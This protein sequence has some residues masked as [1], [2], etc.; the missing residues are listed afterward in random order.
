MSRSANGRSSIHEGADG[1]WHGWVTVGVRPDGTPDRRHRMARTKAELT[2]KVRELEKKRDAGQ[3]TPAGSVPTVAEWLRT[4]L[5]TIAPRTASATTIET[6]YRPRVERWVIP[7]I[8]GHRLDRLRPEHL[9]ALYLDLAA[10][11]LATKS[12]LMVHQILSR[13]YRMAMRRGIVG[14][15]ITAFVDPPRHREPEMSPLTQDEARRILTAAAD[16][17]NSARWSVA[18]ALGLRQAEALGLRWQHVDLDRQQ[19]RVFQLRQEPYRHGCEQPAVCAE[20][21]HRSRCGSGC[22]G[23]ARYC[24]QRVG[25]DW[26]FHEPKGGKARTIVLPA[27]LADQLVQHR[28]AQDAARTAAGPMWHNLDLVFTQPDGRH[29]SPEQDWRAWK[30]LLKAG[31]VPDARL[32]DARHTAATLLL[33][34]GVDIRVVQQILGH[35][36]LAVTKRYTHVTDTLARQAADRMGRALWD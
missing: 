22:A 16:V 35:S 30:G 34:Q 11:G 3:L 36:S 18:L 27:P 23:H 24:P 25:G 32:H 17:P 14:R 28:A 15:N 13:A 12:V 4:W 1:Y 2:T 21:R 9:D 6:V 19:I 20:G 29:L 8:G 10:A 33:E 7:R 31:G 26:R 5:D